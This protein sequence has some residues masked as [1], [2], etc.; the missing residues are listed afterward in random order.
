MS[1][2]YPEYVGD[3]NAYEFLADAHLTKGDKK[4]ATAVLTAYEKMGGE[5]PAMLKKL[6]ALEEELG[7]RKRRLRRWI[8]S[9]ISTR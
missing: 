2:L 8:G 7:R 6:A 9:T 4:A 5:D 1:T 3:A